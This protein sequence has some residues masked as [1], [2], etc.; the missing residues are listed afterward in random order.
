M[1]T[2]YLV[3]LVLS[4]YLL[5]KILK[6][7][8]GVK[9]FFFIFSILFLVISII[10]YPKNSVNAALEAVNTWIFIVIPSL[11]PFF[12]GAELLIHSGIID[13][14]GIVLEP[15]MYPL[16][17]V[18][19][20]GSFVFAMSVTSGYPVGAS[21]I[22][23]LRSNDSISKNE[24]QR[25]IAFSNTSGPLFM[26]GAVAIGML[27][28]PTAGI[29]LSAAHYLSAITVGLLFKYYGKN[30][31]HKSIVTRKEYF[32]RSFNSLIQLKDKRLGSI[33]KIMSKSIESAFSSMFM[34]GG[35]IIIYSVI[36][37]ILNI[38]NIIPN[39][40]VILSNIIPFN[41]DLNIISS[42]LSGLLELTNGCK[43]ISV[44]GVSLISKLCMIS[45]LIG[46]GGF[47]VHGQAISFLSK[48]DIDI[49]LYFFSKIIH[50]TIASIYT[51]LIYIYIPKD[52]INFLPATNFPQTSS[53]SSAISLLRH[54]TSLGI[55][56][57]VLLFSISLILSIPFVI[58]H[59]LNK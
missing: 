14:I 54:S 51:Y 47:S 18:P 21:L 28:N 13:F 27:K 38:T 32:K 16:F 52:K 59:K 33:S 2:L 8:K 42:F 41:L 36:I 15:F 25:L 17:R 39:I 24:A 37:E 50:G 45:F 23:E 49:S 20:K 4:I 7:K 26:I 29:L 40:S 22:S 10:I 53:F 3:L 43:E 1:N 5:F 58:K 56:T 34:I 30:E 55:I 11:F 44:L 46:W 12:I 9:N 6:Y 35:F 48:T 57:F 19:G 31:G